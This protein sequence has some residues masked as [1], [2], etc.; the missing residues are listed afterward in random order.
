MIVKVFRGVRWLHAELQQRIGPAYNVILGVGVV[1]EIIHR[2]REA[3]FHAQ[4]GVI[5]SLLAVV[6]F[7]LL[8][9]NQLAELGE[10]VERRLRRR[11]ED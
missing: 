7:V 5:R 3:N 8:L 9:L 11:R 6:L 1:I 2:V 4:A 10:H